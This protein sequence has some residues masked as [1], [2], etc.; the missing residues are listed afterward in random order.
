MRKRVAV[1]EVSRV[2]KLPAPDEPKT[3]WLPAPPKAIPIPP[4]FPA[5][6]NTTKMRNKQ[7]VM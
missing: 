1:M 3:V 6:S 4:P 2:R 5:C 7:T